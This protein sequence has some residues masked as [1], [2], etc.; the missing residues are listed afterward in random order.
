MSENLIQAEKEFEIAALRAE[1]DRL[2][3]ENTKF[4]ISLRELDPDYDPNKICDVEAICQE[5]LEK[6]RAESAIREL[7]TD[8]AKRLEILHRNLKLAR[9]EDLRVNW[10]GHA[11]RMS[12]TELEKIAKTQNGNSAS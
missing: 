5:Q 11:K 9:G 1:I 10:E 4:R 8:E 2:T 7:S 12:D 6:L 3:K